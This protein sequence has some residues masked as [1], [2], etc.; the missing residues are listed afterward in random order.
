MSIGSGDK[1]SLLRIRL[2]LQ[3]V[4]LPPTRNSLLHVS[5][6]EGVHDKDDDISRNISPLFL[7]DFA[8]ESSMNK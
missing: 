7:T 2:V 1:I 3:M 8:N 6:I 4:L 5:S